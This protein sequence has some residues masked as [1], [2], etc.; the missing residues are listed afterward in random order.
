MRKN[1]IT[2]AELQAHKTSIRQIHLKQTLKDWAF[3][4]VL[5]LIFS[6]IFLS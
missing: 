6:A 3:V 4:G 2:N 5:I 1:K